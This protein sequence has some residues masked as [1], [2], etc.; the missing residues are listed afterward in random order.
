MLCSNSF[1]SKL[2][3]RDAIR[4]INL[5]ASELDSVALNIDILFLKCP[6]TE[7]RENLSG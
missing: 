2:L 5:P 3:S 4:R 1:L 7:E 6:S